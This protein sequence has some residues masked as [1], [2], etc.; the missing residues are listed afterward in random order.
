MFAS[1][2]QDL[3]R[4]IAV[5]LRLMADMVEDP[6]D[7]NDAIEQLHH[8]KSHEA[9]T[10]PVEQLTSETPIE[11]SAD[12]EIAPAVARS[13]SADPIRI[14]VR[15]LE[16]LTGL[17]RAQ[18]QAAAALPD[19]QFE[20]ALAVGVSAYLQVATVRREEPES[21]WKIAGLGLLEAAE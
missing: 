15:R 2:C 21:D 8:H 6:T 5:G 10:L 20:E 4:R 3:A 7:T 13:A 16:R 19:E 18:F 14:S 11:P 17:T 1:D 12:S 9:T